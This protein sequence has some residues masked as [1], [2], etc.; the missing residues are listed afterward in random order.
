MKQK[1]LIINQ[2]NYEGYNSLYNIKS[3]M[4]NG[5]YKNC[6]NAL[7]KCF[8]T[9]LIGAI[10]IMATPLFFGGSLMLKSIFLTEFVTMLVIE[11]GFSIEFLIKA[12]TLKK[13]KVKSVKEIYPYVDTNVDFDELQESLIKYKSDEFDKEKDVCFEKYR[14]IENTNN[15]ELTNGQNMKLV[16]DGTVCFEDISSNE[17]NECFNEKQEQQKSKVKTLIR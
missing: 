1:K 17:Y 16:Q 11:G 6:V 14:N 10:V 9:L 8:I 5:E 12:F 13:E 2:K 3:K 4:S 15:R 7:K